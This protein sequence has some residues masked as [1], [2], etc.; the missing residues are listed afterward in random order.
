MSLV[1]VDA[2]SLVKAF[3]MCD[4][5]LTNPLFH[6]YFRSQVYP[7]LPGVEGALNIAREVR[8]PTRGTL[9]KGTNSDRRET[10]ESLT[11][12]PQEPIYI[13]LP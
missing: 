11:N 10:D 12:H 9:E 13:S 4:F 8:R 1:I 6:L 3:L 2:E 7:S 5:I